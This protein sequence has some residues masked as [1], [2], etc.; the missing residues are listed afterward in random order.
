[1]G[2]STGSRYVR[3]QEVQA[4]EQK[5]QARAAEQEQQKAQYLSQYQ[6][7]QDARLQEQMAA[8]SKE[9]PTTNPFQQQTE[10]TEQGLWSKTISTFKTGYTA[11]R[12]GNLS[13]G[14][15]KDLSSAGWGVEGAIAGKVVS[16]GVDIIGEDR[17]KAYNAGYE[18]GRGR[19]AD[20]SSLEAPN[21]SKE[22]MISSSLYDRT[23]NLTGS[24]S[25]FRDSMVKPVP[26]GLAKQTI[27]GFSDLV[28]MPV[29]LIGKAP[30]GVETIVRNPTSSNNR[31]YLA[32]V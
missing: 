22:K 28:I 5:V 13:F 4:Q 21:Q 25:S 7:Q 23:D 1:M 31:S 19:N 12:S 15:V 20:I 8:V 16:A 9:R 17:L 11:G 30:L 2:E 3:E 24:L 27:V 29:D 14:D 18:M 26:E 32:W 10:P 6:Q